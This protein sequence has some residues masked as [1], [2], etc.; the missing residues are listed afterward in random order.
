[1]F[2]WS[3]LENGDT[4]TIKRESDHVVVRIDRAGQCEE[5][6]VT[7]REVRCFAHDVVTTLVRRVLQ[8]IK[9]DDSP[10]K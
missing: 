4:V 3:E 7:A 8:R 1:M 5:Q 9:N 6:R 2:V 10:C